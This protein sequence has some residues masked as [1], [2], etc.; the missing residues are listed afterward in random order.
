MYYTT[1]YILLQILRKFQSFLYNFDFHPNTY[2]NLNIGI[3]DL[4]VEF[5]GY[6][7]NLVCFQMRSLQHINPIFFLLEIPSTMLMQND[8]LIKVLLQFHHSLQKPQNGN[9]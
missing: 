1:T 3:G 2:V 6:F 4:G 5:K 7:K 9:L 8:T